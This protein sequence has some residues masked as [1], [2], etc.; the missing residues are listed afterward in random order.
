MDVFLLTLYFCL[1]VHIKYV[2]KFWMIY[3]MS[4]FTWND[5]KVFF[6]KKIRWL[7]PTVSPKQRKY[8]PLTMLVGGTH[9]TGP[10]QANAFT[11]SY[12]SSSHL[13]SYYCTETFNYICHDSYDTLISGSWDSN[14]SIGTNYS[15]KHRQPKEAIKEEKFTGETENTI[16]VMRTSVSLPDKSVT[17]CNKITSQ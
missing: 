4:P 16:P 1:L 8:N 10:S 3:F 9:Q 2:T 13:L 15:I 5:Y 12:Y 7:T 11:Q 17:C 14:C 6:F